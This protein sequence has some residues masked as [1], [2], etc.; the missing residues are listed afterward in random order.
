MPVAIAPL[1]RQPRILEDARAGDQRAF[2]LLLRHHDDRM[3]AL[4]WKPASGRRT[5]DRPTDDAGR[6][7]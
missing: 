1:S 5:G 4:A 3:R 7:R 2:S 6:P